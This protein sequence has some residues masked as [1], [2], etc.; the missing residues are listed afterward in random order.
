[1]N[2]HDG[3]PT[4]K[5]RLKELKAE[6]RKLK[7]EQPGL[8]ST[9]FSAKWWPTSATRAVGPVLLVVFVV[10]VIWL[11]GRGGEETEAKIEG[12][13]SDL[14]GHLPTIGSG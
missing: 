2:R 7:A 9:L 10:G 12:N 11:I 5:D 4:P 1:M 8:F 6:Q 14:I 13:F 3:Q